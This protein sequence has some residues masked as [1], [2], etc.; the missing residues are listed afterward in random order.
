MILKE[1]EIEGQPLEVEVSERTGV[2]TLYERGAAG[3]FSARICSSAKLDDAEAEARRK[4]KGKRVHVSVPFIDITT[5]EAGEAYSVHA[6][7]GNVMAKFKGERG[8]YHGG[9]RGMGVRVLDPGMPARALA[10]Y[11]AILAEQRSLEEERKAI[12]DEHSIELKDRVWKAL[13]EA[14][15][16]DGLERSLAM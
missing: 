16:T 12:E 2:F 13:R 15:D 7:N 1:L 10:R 6:G 9:G 14:N 4:L 11:R 5:G 8:N 3:S